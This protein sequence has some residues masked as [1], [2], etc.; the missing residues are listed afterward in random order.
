MI[1]IYR[2]QV[3]QAHP[4]NMAQT[5]GKS[6]NTFQ[7]RLRELAHKKKGGEIGEREPLIYGDIMIRGSPTKL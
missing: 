1:P 3:L 7:L 6:N 5:T 4:E 2:G